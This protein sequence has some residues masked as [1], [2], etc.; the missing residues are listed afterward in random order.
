MCHATVEVKKW[1]NSFG[2][3]IPKE[4]VA[5]LGLLE[6][7]LI[8]IDILKKERVSGFGIAKGKMPFERDEP[9]HEDLW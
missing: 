1:G 6:K 7:D 8:D 9:E 5:E 2:V 4:K 3:I